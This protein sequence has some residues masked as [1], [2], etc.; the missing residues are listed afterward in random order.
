MAALLLEDLEG[1]VEVLVFPDTF[2]KHRDL[3]VTDAPLVIK[4]KLDSDESATRILASD[5]YPIDRATERLSTKVT[6]AID[7]VNAPLDLAEQLKPMLEKKTGHAEVVFELRYPDRYTA[8][9]RP[10]PYL[11]VVPDKEFVSFVEGICG[12]DAVKFS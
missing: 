1:I 6:V 3:L 2:E 12:P 9:V 11:K 7:A 5:V 10:N 8:F 4:G